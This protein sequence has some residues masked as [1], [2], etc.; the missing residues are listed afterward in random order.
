MNSPCHVLLNALASQNKVAKCK[1]P[2]RNGLGL[3]LLSTCVQES[4]G[5]L[6]VG[7]GQHCAKHHSDNLTLERIKLKRPLAE[8]VHSKGVKSAPSIRKA[9][10]KVGA[11][12]DNGESTYEVQNPQEIGLIKSVGDRMTCLADGSLFRIHSHQQPISDMI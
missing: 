12:L 10:I 8:K 1:L 11:I 2:A 3:S 5:G 9:W 7:T 6:L 4:L